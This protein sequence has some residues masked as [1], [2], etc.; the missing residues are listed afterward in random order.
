MILRS[1][2]AKKAE[3]SLAVV[4][5]VLNNSGYVAQDK[6]ERVLRAVEELEYKPNPVARSLKSNRTNQILCYIRDL[7]NSYY[8][9]MY[10]G[11][12]DYATKSGFNVIISGNL[13][14]SQI[15]RLMVDGVIFPFVSPSSRIFL[16]QIKVPMVAACYD[17]NSE[18]GDIHVDVDVG[19]AVRIAVSHLRELGHTEIAYAAMDREKHD[20][21]L[22]AFC[23]EMSGK[24]DAESLIFGPTLEFGPSVGFSYLVEPES[25]IN[26]FEGGKFAARQYLEGDR[27]ATAFLCFNDDTAIGLMSHLQSNGIRIPE[28]MSVIGIDDHFAS[29]Y[30]SPPLT[31][32]TLEPVRHGRECAELMIN[33]ILGH[34]EKTKPEIPCRPIVR[35]ST[36]PL[37]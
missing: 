17:K 26:Y 28:D 1:D 4:S 33:V 3:V 15:K 23:L 6:R 21:R 30:T 27:K 35:E 14:A 7:S 18:P 24:S 9:D 22:N 31:T 19:S 36:A 8:L 5:R 13:D 25:E 20:L 16:N 11:M 37:V 32:V 29:A 10:R 12:M 2:V 34:S